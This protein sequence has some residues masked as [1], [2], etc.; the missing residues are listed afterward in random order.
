MTKH[1][2]SPGTP[3]PDM[4]SEGTRWLDRRAA[5]AWLN[6]VAVVE[7]LPVALDAQLLRDSDLSFVE[8]L[9][10]AQLAES[11]GHTLR[12][13]DLAATTNL[14]LPRISR[15]VARLEADAFVQRRMHARDGRSRQIELTDAGWDKLTTA[16]AGHIGLV[17]EIFVNRLSAEQFEQ[18]TAIGAALAEGLDPKRRVLAQALHSPNGRPGLSRDPG[19]LRDVRP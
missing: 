11:D 2:E 9:V 3:G 7:L 19:E 10:L 13:T 14:G 5:D 6:L 16:S 15:V 1:D 17:N 4:A 12:L 18:L 8:F